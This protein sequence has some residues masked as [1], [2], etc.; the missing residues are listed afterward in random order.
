MRAQVAGMMQVLAIA[1]TPVREQMVT[2]LAESRHPVA[3]KALAQLA[4]F[5]PDA[6][7]RQLAAKALVGRKAAEYTD[8][9]L[10][11]LSYPWPAA[12]NFAVDV[13]VALKRD[14]LVPTLVDMLGDADPR[15][16]VAKKVDGKEILVVRHLVKLN[17]N[18]NC[19]LCHPSAEGAPKSA[20][21][22]PVPDPSKKLPPTITYYLEKKDIIPVRADM[23]YLRQDF[24]MLQHVPNAKPWPDYQRFDFLVRSLTLSPDE[25]K[26]FQNKL[27]PKVG[28]NTPY[29]EALLYALRALTGQDAAPTPQAW[30][31][32]LKL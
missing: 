19:L 17:H 3:T 24:S 21:T 14:D 5:A 11:G 32:V 4:V 7:V 6:S 13:I 31:K 20:V 1:A 16:P 22:A 26:V 23:T 27:Q 9:L 2:I 8:V 25:A 18:R 28:E 10:A 29:Q 15:L 30:K 12:A